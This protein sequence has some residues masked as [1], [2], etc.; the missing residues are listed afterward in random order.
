MTQPWTPASHSG[1]TSQA[2]YDQHVL[3][4]EGQA[5]SWGEELVWR[6]FMLS[7]L[8][9]PAWEA[10]PARRELFFGITMQF[11]CCWVRSKDVSARTGGF[12]FTWPA[13]HC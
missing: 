2:S 5:L 9:G 7:M 12:L 13:R 1:R 4:L 10:G 6:M 8:W 11:A 3:Q